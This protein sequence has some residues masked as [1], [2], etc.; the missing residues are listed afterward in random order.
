MSFVDKRIIKNLYFKYFTYVIYNIL[1]DFLFTIYY[2]YIKHFIFLFKKTRNLI[3]KLPGKIYNLIRI[4]IINFA[5][6]YF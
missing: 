1:Y 4:Y 5:Y 2:L 6:F 3:K